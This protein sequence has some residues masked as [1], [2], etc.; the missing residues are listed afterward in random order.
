MTYYTTLQLARSKMN[1]ENT[2]A[3][4]DLAEI[5]PFASQ[6]IEEFCG[7]N[8]DDRIETRY[9]S[10]L[11]GGGSPTLFLQ[12]QPLMSPTGVINGDGTVVDPSVYTAIPKGRYPIEELRLAVNNYWVGTPLPGLVHIH[13]AA[14]AITVGGHWG[15][16]RKGLAAWRLSTLTV[17]APGITDLTGTA[18]PL[19]AAAAAK[20][21]VGSIL[22]LGANA[23]SEQVF[24]TGPVALT[25]AATTLTV[26]RGE[27]GTAAATHAA[28]EPIYV[29]EVEPTINVATAML[30]AAQYEAR[31]NPSGEVM[32][33]AGFGPFS[34]RELPKKVT[35]KL[36]APLW[37]WRYGQLRDG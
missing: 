5:L 7:Q 33:A 17:A 10:A 9:F 21:D 19:S 14:D 31:Q 25:S 8:F 32:S 37:N 15:F 16:N 3:D 1:T 26:T 12:F 36:Q 28:S 6:A 4:A 24:V 27:N 35:D 11:V 20:I 23:D 13:Y 22:R 30:A 29:W 18:L 2:E 34:T